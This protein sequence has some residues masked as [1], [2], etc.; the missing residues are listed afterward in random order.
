MGSLTGAVSSQ[1]VTE[2]SKGSLSTVGNRAKSVKA[3]GS[4]TARHTSRADAKA[5]LSDPAVVC[6]NAVAQRI[7]GTPGIT[8][9]SPPRV[10][11]DG[12]VWHLDVGSSHPGAGEGPKGLAVRQLKRYVSWV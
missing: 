11:I 4:L 8:G 6:G 2:E 9:L 10:H 7:K 5:G 12:V 3:K 1:I